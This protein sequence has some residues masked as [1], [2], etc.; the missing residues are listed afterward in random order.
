MKGV[1]VRCVGV[2][3]CGCVGVCCGHTLDIACEEGTTDMEAVQVNGKDLVC[4][5]VLV[6]CLSHASYERP[7]DG[8]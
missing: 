8:T 7:F 1:G 2:W 4:Y 3:A 5:E 6:L